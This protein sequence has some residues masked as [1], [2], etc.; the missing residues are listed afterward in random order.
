MRRSPVAIFPLW[1]GVKLDATEAETDTANATSRA[2][3]GG[4]VGKTA[5]VPR[6]V[7]KFASK[8]DKVLDFG[9]GKDAYFTKMLRRRG[10]NVTAYDFG[11]NVN[12]EIHDTKALSRKYDVV[13]ASNVLNVQ[14]SPSMLSET[15]AQIKRAVSAG[16]VAI[17]NYPSSPHKIE[18]LDADKL[19]GILG[20]SFNVERIAG[21]DSVPIWKLTVS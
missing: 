1:G 8:T 14:S 15:I 7:P 6:L 19:K 10:Y 21:T 2:G 17:V 9:A 13:F 16:G 12:P 4:A 5:L 11:D 20:R 3:S 18:S